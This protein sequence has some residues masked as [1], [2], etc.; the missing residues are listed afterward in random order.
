[1]KILH[2]AV[3]LSVLAATASAA[4]VRVSGDNTWQVFVNGDKVAEGA[5]WQAP[6]VTE[7]NLK[8]D[9]AFVAIYVHDAEPG[10]AG[11]GGF[12]A[13]II[14]DD[15]TYIPSAM[16]EA[17]VCDAGDPVANRKDGWEQPGFDA[18]AW[19]Q[20]TQYQQFGQGVWGFGA[21]AMTAKFGD[22]PVEAFWC[23]CDANNVTDD[24]YFIYQIGT[25]AVEP[26]GKLATTWASL[27][28]K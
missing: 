28:D 7:F 10:G 24:V 12:I 9:S 27:K 22:P 14:L 21:A 13:D 15:G 1:M 16:E 19:K 25:L 11:V 6:T 5:D 3:T 26:Q 18:A 23:W 20:L 17:W 2:W 4:T 8:N